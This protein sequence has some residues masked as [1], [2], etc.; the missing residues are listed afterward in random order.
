MCKN[1]FI[2]VF[3][4]LGVVVVHWGHA[5]TSSGNVAGQVALEQEVPDE[6]LAPAAIQLYKKQL[7]PL[8]RA[9]YQATRETI[10]PSILER[11]NEAKNLLQSGADVKAADR[12]GR[13]ALH[14]AVFGSSYST[15]PK[16]IVQ[17]EEI[18]HE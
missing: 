4:G 2:F 18:A 17:Y 14:W 10:E 3:L 12:Q 7:S 13:T 9:L 6:E 15:K 16:V 5:Q 11:L 1:A 8:L